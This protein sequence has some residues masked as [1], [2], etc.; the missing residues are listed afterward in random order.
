MNV[1]AERDESGEIRFYEGS[2]QDITD[3]KRAE[4]ALQ[5]QVRLQE[6]LMS[7]SATYINLPL[8]AVESQIS[9]SLGE[10]AK[11]VGATRAFVFEYDLRDQ[12]MRATHEWFRAG[13]EPRIADYKALPLTA[14]YPDW[15]LQAHRRGESIR[16]PDVMSLPPGFLK[17][18]LQR[19]GTRSG[20][21]VPC[22]SEGECL[23][24]VGFAWADQHVLSANEERLLLVFANMR[25]ASGDA[26]IQRRLYGRAR[27]ISINCLNRI[28]MPSYYSDR[29]QRRSSTLILP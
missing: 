13:M 21:Y 9:I 24:F 23:G 17:E 1:R 11:C 25:R 18:T 12:I 16:I 6:L 10:M 20:L 5:Y 7:M 26:G 19:G 28:R 22:M 15:D 27:H 8:E 14:V 29:A 4:E 3:R 2:L